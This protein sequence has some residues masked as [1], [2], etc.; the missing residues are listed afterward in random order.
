MTGAGITLVLGAGGT[1]GVAHAGILRRLR[2]ERVP[3]DTI[4]GCSVGAIVGACHAAVG[5][6]PDELIEAARSLGPASLLNFALSRWRLPVL[7]PR[8]LRRAGAI[9]G[10]LRRLRRASFETLSHGIRRLGILVYD[11]PRREELLLH[12]GPGR[13]GPLP[14]LQAVKASA[15]IPGLF[16]PLRARLGGPT[17]Y[18]VD[19]GWHTA[20]PVERAFAPPIGARRVVAVDLS[21]RLCVRQARRSYWNQLQESCGDRL[22]LLRPD[23]RGCGTVVARRGDVD[24]L[25][26]AGE[27]CVDGAPLALLRSWVRPEGAPQAGFP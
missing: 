21:I 22:I 24:R 3:I 18:L 16:P 13:P 5:M 23:V 25:A 19:A 14:L 8:A 20:V 15:A 12:G 11:L 17:R 4:I 6:E 2:S 27:A 10:P 7:S 9:V 1:R 26:A